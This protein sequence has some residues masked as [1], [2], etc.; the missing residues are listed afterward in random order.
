MY[1][2]T[3]LIAILQFLAAC[4][5]CKTVLNLGVYHLQKY[6]YFQT[7]HIYIYKQYIQVVMV[8]VI[9]TQQNSQASLEYV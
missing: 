6:D 7:S 2:I 1:N 3:K 9:K 5:D 8:N 4:I